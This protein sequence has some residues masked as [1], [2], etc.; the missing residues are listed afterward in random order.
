VTTHPG[1]RRQN[2]GLHLQSTDLLV[3][4]VD[5]DAGVHSRAL[6]LEDV[7]FAQE[8]DNSRSVSIDETIIVTTQSWYA[9]LFAGRTP[10]A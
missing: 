1:P 5:V 9:M 8:D 10:T 3:E 7:W 6:A 4:L 2:I